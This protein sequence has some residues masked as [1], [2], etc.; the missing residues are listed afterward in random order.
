MEKNQMTP[1]E[2]VAARKALGLTQEHLARVINCDRST[3]NR[4]EKSKLTL[5]PAQERLIALYLDGVRPPDWPHAI[6]GRISIRK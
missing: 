1:A 5:H 2:I 6:S 3:L 4:A